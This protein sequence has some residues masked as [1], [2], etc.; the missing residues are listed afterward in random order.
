MPSTSAAPATDVRIPS[1]IDDAPVRILNVIFKERALT[2]LQELGTEVATK[3]KQ[4]IC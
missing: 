2:Q 1:W 3:K 4:I